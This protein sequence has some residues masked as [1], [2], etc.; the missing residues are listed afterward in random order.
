[1]QDNGPEG[2]INSISHMAGCIQSS[3]SAYTAGTN[4]G[5]ANRA[6]YCLILIPH[7]VTITALWWINGTLASG[8]VDT[9]IYD[10]LT[11][12]KVIT[13][14]STARSGTNVLQSVTL[15]NSVFLRPGMYYLAH[16]SD[17]STNSR[18]VATFFTVSDMTILAAGIETSAF[19]LPDPI[20]PVIATAASTPYPIIGCYTD[21]CGL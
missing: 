4:W 20:T 19:P 12:K 2:I 8:N 7:G 16:N 14:G 18:T 5:V 3:G 17:T 13:T 1:M 6:V 9:G 15:T 11:H 21:K 10:A